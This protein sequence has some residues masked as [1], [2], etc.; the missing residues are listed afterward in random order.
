[1]L[2]CMSDGRAL[3][4][5][6]RGLARVEFE[7]FRLNMGDSRERFVESAEMVL[8]GLEQGYCEYDGKHA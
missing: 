3:F 6:G 4:G 2:D 8:Q 7:G 1:M 5:I